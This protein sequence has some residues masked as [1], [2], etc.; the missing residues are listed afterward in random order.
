M[1]VVTIAIWLNMAAKD[2]SLGLLSVYST[3]STWDEFFESV[4]R[5]CDATYQ[6]FVK[7]SSKKQGETLVYQTFL[8]THRGVFTPRGR[9]LRET[10]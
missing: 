9:G 8:C 4:K 5:Y 10:K 7:R 1:T 2:P 3:F 6:P